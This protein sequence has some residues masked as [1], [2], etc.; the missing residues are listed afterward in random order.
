MNECRNKNIESA[1]SW[2]FGL[3][4]ALMEGYSL[5][6]DSARRVDSWHAIMCLAMDA[7]ESNETLQDHHLAHQVNGLWRDGPI[8]VTIYDAPRVEGSVNDN[9]LAA[10]TRDNARRQQQ[11]PVYLQASVSKYLQL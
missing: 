6:V 10:M 9:D 8:P 11:E 3:A 7:L 2:T 1:Q 5:T 4:E